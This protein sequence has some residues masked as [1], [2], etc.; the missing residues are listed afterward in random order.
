MMRLGQRDCAGVPVVVVPLQRVALVVLPLSQRER[1]VADDVLRLGPFV[2][3]LLHRRLVRRSGG[4]VGGEHR[5]ISRWALAGHD[6]RLVVGRLDTHVV[7][8]QAARSEVE[9]FAVL[10]VVEEAG[11][12]SRGGRIEL[13]LI[14]I[15][16]VLRRDRVAVAPLGIAQ[17]ERPLRCVG[18][19]LPLFGNVRLY[20]E[21]LVKLG[22]L[23]K[24]VTVAVA[25][26]VLV[27]VEAV[28]LDRAVDGEDL[29]RARSAEPLD[30]AVDAAVEV[31][32]LVAADV[33]PVVAALVA[34]A[35]VAVV[36]PSAR[37]SAVEA[38]RPSA[39]T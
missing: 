38:E 33:A 14:G 24:A 8:G 13:T 23:C 21:V 12:R 32:A 15:L 36:A 28:W 1:A 20:G 35:D 26:E 3:E 18:V 11:I 29:I 9:V 22:Q 39:L 19:R 5:K 2:A 30:V 37:S 7:G 25:V 31:A 4:R 17:V 16:V 10:D 6:Q 34:A 27:E